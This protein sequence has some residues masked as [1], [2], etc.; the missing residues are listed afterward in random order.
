NIYYK[1][2]VQTNV[3]QDAGSLGAAAVA[4]I[5]AGLWQSWEKVKE[6]HH[7]KN[8]IKPTPE[9]NEQYERLLPVFQFVCNIQSDVGDRLHNLT[10]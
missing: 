7:V 5:G 10:L 8:V 2:I 3:G 4:A 9:I 1:N 6:I